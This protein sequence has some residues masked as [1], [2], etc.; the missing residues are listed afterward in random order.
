MAVLQALSHVNCLPLLAHSITQSSSAATGRAYEALLVFPAYQVTTGGQTSQSSS[1]FTCSLPASLYAS[2]P[3]RAALLQDGT[4]LDELDRLAVE[5]SR[6]S[7]RQVL[8]VFRQ[9]RSQR[10]ACTAAAASTHTRASGALACTRT[11]RPPRRCCCRLLAARPQIC[12]GVSHMHSRGFAH[13]DLKPH[14]ILIKRPATTQQQQQQ[15]LLT[16]AANPGSIPRPG[17]RPRIRA[18]ALP[19]SDEEVD[20]EA[21][22][23]LVSQLCRTVGRQQ[24]AR[25]GFS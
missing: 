1:L 3:S 9:V 13:M 7:S 15:R 5:G 14:N 17:S 6:L 25:L 2:G 23:S 18:T 21:G 16:A 11:C 19:D 22:A 20:L 12:A 24:W 4:L 10:L 8:E